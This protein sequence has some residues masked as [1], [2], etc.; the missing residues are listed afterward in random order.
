MTSIKRARTWVNIVSLSP[1]TF[2]PQMHS[3]GAPTRDPPVLTLTVGMPVVSIKIG[4]HYYHDL[5]DI[6]ASVSA[7]PFT[8]YQEIVN[9]ISPAEIH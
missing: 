9:D 8:L 5:C 3:L 6:G 4:A 1:V 7:I 2:D